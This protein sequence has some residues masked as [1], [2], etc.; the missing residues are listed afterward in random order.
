MTFDL[1]RATFAA[2]VLT[3]LALPWTTAGFT[4]GCGLAT[5]GSLLL[6]RRNTLNL[7]HPFLVPS[8]LWGGALLMSFLWSHADRAGDEARTY[9]PFL[10]AFVASSVVRSARQVRIL[11]FALLGSASITAAI[12]CCHQ[13]GWIDAETSRYSGM[14]TIFTYAMV[15]ATS[16]IIA[17]LLF[18]STKHRG[19]QAMAFVMGL[20]T[21]GGIVANGSRAILIAV[22]AAYLVILAL[23]HR[24]RVP[25]LLF[26][27]PV[28]AAAPLVLQTKMGKRLLYVQSELHLDGSAPSARE[29]MWVVA[30][31][32]FYDHP[33]MGVG[34]GAYVEE[35]D[36]IFAQGR[37]E[38]YPTLGDG[39]H[40]AHNIL[41]HIAATMGTVGLI[42]FAIWFG[43]YIVYFLR[44]RARD[45]LLAA[46][47]LALVA[48]VLGFG[49]TDMS[50]LNSRITGLLAIAL[51]ACLGAIRAQEQA[52]L[53]EPK[54]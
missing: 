7:E 27:L 15:M 48:L 51:G 23:L 16:Y 13:L 50:L 5:L 37:M 52:A 45:R 30:G 46:G 18:A 6:W 25:L 54:A 21:L 28:V 36:A 12:G 10:L 26:L 35:R 22:A 47:A 42:A 38:G 8:L 24:R 53:T 40:T 2:L 31:K 17:A 34:V 3:L 1:P 41:L 43:G 49:V 39:Y 19:V 20:I 33:Y 4:I 29:A 11:A 32:M 44:H 14:V 9:Y